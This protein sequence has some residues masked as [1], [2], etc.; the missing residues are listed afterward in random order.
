MRSLNRAK[1]ALKLKLLY[2]FPHSFQG[3]NRAKVALK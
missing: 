1:V 2:H 3:L